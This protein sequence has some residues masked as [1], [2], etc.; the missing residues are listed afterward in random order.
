MK[1][2]PNRKLTANFSLYEFIEDQLPAEA[3]ALNWQHINEMK[4][5]E[6]EELAK[7][8]QTLRN[9]INQ[10]WK[11][12]NGNNEICLQITSGFRCKA[13]ELL[14]GRN[15]SS[16][17]CQLAAA[18]VQPTNCPREMA[19]E[20]LMYYHKKYKD[21]HFGGL[22]IKHAEFDSKGKILKVGFLHFDFR[23]YRARWT[24]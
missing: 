14:R 16:M 23:G 11:A 1:S 9:D 12:A 20:I 2:I 7:F 19:S 15:G 13:W 6:F 10:V 24:Y 21:K 18:D 22:A 4:I 5:P 17:H 8:L 3:V